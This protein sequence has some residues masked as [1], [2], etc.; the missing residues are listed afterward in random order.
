MQ[1]EL[2][3]GLAG[4]GFAFGDFVL[5]M[6]EGEVYA[7]GVNVQ[8]FAE[9]FHGHG[10]AFDVPAWTAGA[11]AGLPEMLTRFGSFPEGEIAGI[12]FF[13][14]IVIHAGASF[15]SAQIN[16]GE[17][18]VIRKFSDAVVDGTFT[19]I[20]EAFF[21]QAGNQ[22]DHVFD[23]VGGA[24]GFLGLLQM[25]RVHIFEEGLHVFFGVFAD[26][27]ARGRGVL[28]DAIVHVGKVHDLQDAQAAGEQEAAQYVL[29]DENTKIADMGIVV[30]WGAAAVD[31]DFALVQGLEGLEAAG[32]RV[33]ET[34]VCH[35]QRYGKRTIVA[36]GRVWGKGRN[37][38]AI[39][40]R[41]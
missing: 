30:D 3:E 25:Q 23:V 5:V 11:D 40:D 15:H 2:H 36:E 14:A 13:V 18:A 19:G 21:L 27:D 7:A 1:P 26:R 32:E 22:R 29:E 34:Y 37:G 38:N 33:V 35:F 24:H 10:G 39:A 41:Q 28:D 12:V 9:I 20:G 6:R 31:A 16:L 8:S 4:G 17:L